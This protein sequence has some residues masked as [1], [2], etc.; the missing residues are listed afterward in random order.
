MIHIFLTIITNKI[1]Y[2]SVLSWFITQNLK[3][4]INFLTKKQIKSKNTIF[5]IELGGMPSVHS[6]FVSSLSTSVGLK[7]GWDNPIFIVTLCFSC[8]VIADAAGFRRATGKQAKALNEIVEEL[9]SIQSF[10][11]LKY[12]T[13]RELLGHTPIE[14][15]VG[16]IVGIIITFIF[17]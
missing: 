11:D 9:K 2:I 4:L 1:F 12:E 10:K 13:V 14:V 15:F 7:L 5:L 16:I 17:Y 8:I 6:A 3:F